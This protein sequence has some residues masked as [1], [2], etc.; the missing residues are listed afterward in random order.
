MEIY[1]EVFESLQLW[2]NCCVQREARVSF[3]GHL[4]FMPL[5][6]TTIYIDQSRVGIH[7]S[8]RHNDNTRPG[9]GST[10]PC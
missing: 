9:Y 2:G 10:A 3:V 7:S 5:A 1:R 4:N 8:D 6:T